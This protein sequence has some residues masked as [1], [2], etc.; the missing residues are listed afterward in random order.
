MKTKELKNYVVTMADGSRYSIPLRIIA[1]DRARALSENGGCSG[2]F[3][4]AL[5]DSFKLFESNPKK[6][7]D[8]IYDNITWTE[9]K[10][11][12]TKLRDPDPVD[13]E[14]SWKR[15]SHWEIK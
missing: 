11:Y 4:E 13:Y 12:A 9:I 8:W 2:N 14:E 3:S 10:H 1:T 5:S 15:P 6:L 7:K